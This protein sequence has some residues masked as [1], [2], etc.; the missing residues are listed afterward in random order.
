MA[1][2][3]DFSW[4][5]RHRSRS[6]IRS[7]YLSRHETYQIPWRI[8]LFNKYHIHFPP[9]GFL[10]SISRAPINTHDANGVGSRMSGF[11]SLAIWTGSLIIQVEIYSWK[12]RPGEL[13]D[14]DIP[15]L[16]HPVPIAGFSRLRYTILI[17]L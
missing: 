3:S 11:V 17:L 14:V 9:T 13:R 1:S 15:H 5:F 16:F 7:T 8:C 2:S 6:N 4:C 12:S 10:G